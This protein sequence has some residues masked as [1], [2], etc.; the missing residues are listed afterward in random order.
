MCKLLG[1]RPVISKLALITKVAGDQIKHR[2]ILD[3]L[4]SA[5]DAW[6]VKWERT[7]LPK[8]LDLASDLL[9]LLAKM[10]KG[11]SEDENL[12]MMVLDFVDAF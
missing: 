11:M 6:A 5:A 12:F 9:E 7:L 2:L 1:R 8:I 4:R 3:C 10:T